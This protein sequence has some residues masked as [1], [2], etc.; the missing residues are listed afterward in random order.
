M[1]QLRHRLT[2]GL[3]L[4]ALA[5]A[6]LPALAAEG[7]VNINTATAAQLELLPRIGPS[8]AARIVEHRKAN[9]QFKTPEDLMLVRGI[10]Q[11]AFELLKPYVVVSG[12]TTLRDKVRV[13][14]NK[15]AAAKAE[16][17]R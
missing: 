6:G 13:P 14:R 1:L 15:P 17:K 5:L 12:E 9:G 16:D 8:V 10:G 4:A 3:L 11:K 2:T 7:K